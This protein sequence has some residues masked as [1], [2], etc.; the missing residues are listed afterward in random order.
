MLREDVNSIDIGDDGKLSESGS[1]QT[2]E[3]A[4]L[5][6]WYILLAVSLSVLVFT[7][8]IKIKKRRYER[9]C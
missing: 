1:P 9:R 5:T 6:V 8:Y 2:G 4:D 7:G 3:N